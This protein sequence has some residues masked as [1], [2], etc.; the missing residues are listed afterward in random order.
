MRSGFL[1][2][3]GCS[4]SLCDAEF[5]S[6]DCHKKRVP[7]MEDEMKERE[8]DEPLYTDDNPFEAARCPS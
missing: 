4:G 3:S 1:C 8:T 7:I 6:C 2:E 5:C